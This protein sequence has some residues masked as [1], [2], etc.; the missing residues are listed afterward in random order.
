MTFRIPIYSKILAIG[1]VVHFL[2]SCAETEE[3]QTAEPENDFK[4]F[5]SLN[6]EATGVSLGVGLFCCSST[7]PPNIRFQILGLLA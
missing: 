5:E 6:A 1:L 4:I 3:K 7:Y 2:T